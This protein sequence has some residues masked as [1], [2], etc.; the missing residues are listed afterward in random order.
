[1]EL[2]NS[3]VFARKI[4]RPFGDTTS[5]CI[6]KELQTTS[7]LCLQNPH[8]NIVTVF[9][10]GMLDREY[11]H[12]DMQ[13][14]ELNL[15]TYIYRRWSTELEGKLPEFTG[16]HVPSEVRMSQFW[17]IMTDI[18]RG[19]EF[20]HLQKVIHRDIKPRNS[21]FEISCG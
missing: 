18:A 5:E 17:E 21:K 4:I 16:P 6:E 8:Q 9:K 2:V 20:I 14:C 12:I 10:H 15:D 3:K 1:M 13:F 11:Y 19:L 7:K